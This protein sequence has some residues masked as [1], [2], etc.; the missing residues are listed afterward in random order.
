M[1]WGIQLTIRGM[2]L[3]VLW[4][5]VG[6]SSMAAPSRPAPSGKPAATS[7]KPGGRTV[8]RPIFQEGI[9]LFDGGSYHRAIAKFKLAFFH[10]PSPRIHTRIALSYKWLQQYVLAIE[11]YERYLALT[12]PRTP[13]QRPAP[14]PIDKSLR[15][16]VQKTLVALMRKIGRLK[17]KVTRPAGATIRINGQRVGKAPF[18][19]E[20][21]FMPGMINI[22][23][24]AK[25]HQTFRW[26]VNLQAGQQLS[27]T[28]GLNRIKPAN[29]GGGAA[30]DSL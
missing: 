2:V 6:P 5:S 28:V 16:A 4:T 1:R 15:Q 27:R 29:R 24:S 3:V 7:S 12:A 23:V 26:D 9:R 22:T 11:H 30:A 20:L 25:E 17:L 13:P 21:R 10:Y 19:Q 18:N 14:W 8:A